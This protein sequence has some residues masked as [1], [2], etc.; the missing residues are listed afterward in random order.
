MLM[1]KTIVKKI[2]ILHIVQSPGG[3]ERYIKM[4]LRNFD[5]EHF[6]NIM[7]S[8]YDYHRE[9]YEGL[10]SA[11]ENVEMHRNIDLIKDFQAIC[12][13]RRIIKKYQPDVVYMHS[14]KAGADGRIANLGLNN[15]SVYNPHGWAFN[16]DCG[17]KKRMV[18]KA[19][20]RILAPL[21]TKIITISE[22]EKKSAIKNGICKA[23]KLH[24]IFNGVDI[25]EYKENEGGYCITNQDLGIPDDAVIFGTVGRLSRQ[26]APDTFVKMARLI[27]NHIPEAYFLF[28]GNGEEEKQV[29]TLVSNKGLDDCVKIT[30]WVNEPMQYIKLFD[31]AFLLSRWEGFGLVLAEYMLAKKPIVATNVDAIPDLVINGYNGVLVK[32]DSPEEACEATLRIVNDYSLRDKLIKNGFETVN[33]RFDVRR[34]AEETQSLIR[35]LVHENNI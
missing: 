1:S 22:F 23:D 25:E 35:G 13:L 21:C 7:V 2:R 29:K 9:E 33:T 31:V 34:V 26:K 20:E 11:F 14:S 6:D 8:S 19:I 24:V 5:K 10:V 32:P 30:G 15:I 4:L 16:M 18:Y 27:K 17:K 3:V 28:V 12:N